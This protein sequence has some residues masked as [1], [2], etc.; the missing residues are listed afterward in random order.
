MKNTTLMTEKVID[1]IEEFC[2][3]LRSN[4]QEYAISRHRDYINKEENVDYHIEQINKLALGEGVD[5]FTYTKGRKYAKIIHT[6]N[7]GGQRSC[8]AFVDMNT[9][10]VMKAASWSAPAKGVRYNLMDDK[11]REEMYKRASWC[12][13]YLYK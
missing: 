10:D 9:G 5:D 6:T 12:G 8:H 4:Y 11:C 7:P 1:R 13:S 2:R 3:V